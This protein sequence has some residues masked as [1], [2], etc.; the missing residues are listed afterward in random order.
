MSTLTA[1]SLVREER[2]SRVTEQ[3]Q[4][5]LGPRG[6]ALHVQKGPELELVGVCHLQQTFDIGA[7]VLVDVE[8]VILVTNTAPA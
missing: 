6:D 1:L 2:M 7:K 8:K 3:G 4:T 5:A